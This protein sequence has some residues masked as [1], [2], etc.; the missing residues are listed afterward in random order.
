M[1]GM[2]A[3]QSQSAPQ[4][5]EPA[6]QSEKGQGLARTIGIVSRRRYQAWGDESIRAVFPKVLRL[7]LMFVVK[8]LDAF[9]HPDRWKGRR[10]EEL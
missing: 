6:V 10:R 1:A 9:E 8:T 7:A 5:D 3:K 4:S 2:C